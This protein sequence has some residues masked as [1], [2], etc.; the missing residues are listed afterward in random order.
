MNTGTFE[1][2]E[3]PL[4]ST[5]AD[6]EFRT[7]SREERELAAARAHFQSG[8]VGA[9]TRYITPFTEQ[10]MSET[11]AQFPVDADQYEKVRATSRIV[12]RNYF[13][14][15]LTTLLLFSAMVFS[16]A[17][18]FDAWRSSFLGSEPQPLMLAPLWAALGDTSLLRSSGSIFGIGAGFFALRIVAR[19]LVFWDLTQRAERLSFS[20]FRRIDDIETRVTEACSKVRLRVG[21]NWPRRAKNWIIIALWNAKRSEYLDRFV[22]TVIWR[23]RTYIVNWETFF[24]FV[25][26]AIV[27]II[28]ID[29]EVVAA[30]SGNGGVVGAVFAGLMFLQAYLLWHRAD[31]RPT[32]FWTDT[33]R[34][35]APGQQEDAEKYV[36][37]I[38]DEI[39]N[40]VHEVISKEFGQAGKN[41]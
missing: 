19:K 34:R 20:V 6:D 25:K 38:S 4:H 8:E 33:F 9:P 32:S 21:D 1:A 26:M 22:T 15:R 30:D 3:V 37:K 36:D 13:F 40:L 23:V 7:E 12:I 39:E 11:A 29:L 41:S 35:S 5:G 17:A 24:F 27:T 18:I 28:L 2:S 16:Q 31:Q 10:L 14:L